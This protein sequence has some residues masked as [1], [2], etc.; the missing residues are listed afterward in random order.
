MYTWADGVAGQPGSISPKGL[1][2]RAQQ[3]SAQQRMAS[4]QCQKRRGPTLQ[5]LRLDQQPI[6]RSGEYTALETQRAMPERGT[7]G[8]H[9]S[10]VQAAC[11]SASG[12]CTGK[13]LYMRYAAVNCEGTCWCDWHW[14]TQKDLQQWSSCCCS[15]RGPCRSGKRPQRWRQM[16]CP[17]FGP[18]EYILKACEPL[19]PLAC[20]WHAHRVSI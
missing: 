11:Y 9:T 14:L 4:G 17:D 16:D 20:Y 3:G 2:V 7:S 5:G 10:R 1:A 19:H 12:A 6:I 18:W 8:T 13:S 15:G